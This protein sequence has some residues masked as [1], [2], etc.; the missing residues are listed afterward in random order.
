MRESFKKILLFVAMCT[1]FGGI[2][3]KSCEASENHELLD[4]ADGVYVLKVEADNTLVMNVTGNSTD[5]NTNIDIMTDA[6]IDC[7]KFEITKL[8]DGYYKIESISA[9]KVLTIADNSSAKEANVQLNTFEN[10]DSQKWHFLYAGEDRYLIKSALGTYIDNYGGNLVDGNNVWMYEYN[11]SASQMWMMMLADTVSVENGE[12]DILSDQPMTFTGTAGDVIDIMDG[13]YCINVEADNSYVMN[14][15]GNYIDDGASIDIMPN[16]N[17]D[18]QKFKIEK[19]DDGYYTITAQNSGKVLDVAGGSTASETN[20]QQRTYDGSSGQKW[21]F[22]YVDENR[23]K[24][25]SALGTYIDNY[26]GI[27]AEGNNVWMYEKSDS[28]SQIWMLTKVIKGEA[29]EENWGILADAPERFEGNAGQIIDIKEGIYCINVEEDNSYVMN[30]NGNYTDDGTSI[31]IMPNNNIDC[32]KFKIEKGNDGY[33]TITAQNSGKVLDVEDGSYAPETNLQQRT[34]DG[35]SGQKWEFV[36]VDANRIKI[37]SALGTYIDN[38]G[39]IIADANNVWMYGETDS[40]SQIW[41]LTRVIASGDEEALGSIPN[42]VE[43]ENNELPDGDYIIVSAV[44]EELCVSVADEEAD[45][46]TNII[47]ESNKINDKEKF[48]ISKIDD[49]TYTIISSMTEKSLDIDGGSAENG[50]NVQL[51][52]YDGTYGQLWT[53]AK[54]EDGSVT[55]SSLL[56]TVLSADENENICMMDSETMTYNK[57]KFLAVS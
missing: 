47:L 25:R 30:V 49:D 10:L 54:N 31:D 22:I 38:Y 9:K 3:S 29:V 46:G 56:G 43:L 44:D 14:V 33:Y 21:E 41:M 8:D 15:N 5:E 20:L 57:W 27:I 40:A 11:G 17:I 39:G 35:S 13:I 7:Q 4:I 28:A 36:Y 26:G 6:N 2:I 55:I 16:K 48:R 23:I 19:Q 1:L 51:W 50:A 18:C 53:F 12:Q 45:N 24:I 34:Y 37:R 32:Q 42:Y 52:E